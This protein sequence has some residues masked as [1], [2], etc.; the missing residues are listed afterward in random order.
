MHNSKFKLSLLLGSLWLL[1]ACATNRPVLYST[2]GAAPIG[3]DVTIA[4]CEQLATAAG[5]HAGG[6]QLGDTARNTAKGAAAGAATGAIGGA[7]AG[8]AARGA[9]IG[10]VTGIAATLISSLFNAP[11][12]NPAYRAYVER[13]LKD[14]GFDPVGWQ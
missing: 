12:P 2:G 1:T 13:C 3:A 9:G 5:A 14:R 4:E 8:Q 10:A 6:G 7:F 11:A